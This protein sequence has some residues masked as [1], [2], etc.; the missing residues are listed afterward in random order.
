MPTYRIDARRYNGNL[1]DIDL[2]SVKKTLLISTFISPT[3]G[4]LAD[5]EGTLSNADNGVSAFNGNA[6]TY[7]GSGTVQ[8]GIRVAGLI[9]PTGTAVD[10]VVFDAG[11]ET[12]F[13][14]PDG[15]PGPLATVAMLVTIDTD[16]YEVFPNPHLGNSA[17]NTFNGDAFN[18]IMTG[19]GNNDF[20]NGGGGND[21]IDGGTGNDVLHGNDGADT[22]FGGDGNDKIYGDNDKDVIDGGAG[23]DYLSGGA[24]EDRLLGGIGN[25]T[26]L[27]G[28]S[29]A[30]SGYCRRPAACMSIRHDQRSLTCPI[31][32]LPLPSVR[33]RLC[34]PGVP[35]VCA[36]PAR[37]RRSFRGTW[38]DRLS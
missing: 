24:R 2:I 31:E 11:G 4:V 16:P 5:N 14:F 21:R 3:T 26:L 13:H 19:E 23:D 27:G 15:Q 10:V 34:R 12:Y 33:H 32:G 22:I 20:I 9:V 25:D 37:C 18:N 17:I 28:G 29:E 35:S 7:V 36:E 30:F 6:L 38:G 8:A 1:L